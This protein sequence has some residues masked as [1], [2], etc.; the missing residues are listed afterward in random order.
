MQWQ[1]VFNN[2]IVKSFENNGKQT[3]LGEW[4]DAATE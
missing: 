2:K 3:L 1:Q 4:T